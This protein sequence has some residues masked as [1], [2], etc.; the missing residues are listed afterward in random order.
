MCVAGKCVPKHPDTYK[1][2]Y[3]MDIA[4]VTFSGYAPAKTKCNIK[5]TLFDLPSR[6]ALDSKDPVMKL[7]GYPRITKTI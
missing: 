3:A 2:D 7:Q 1:E 4:A 6:R 5:S